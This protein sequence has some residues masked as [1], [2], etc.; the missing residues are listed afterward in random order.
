MALVDYVSLFRSIR[1]HV[2]LQSNLHVS[3]LSDAG[4]RIIQGKDWWLLPD[5]PVRSYAHDPDSTL[6]Q[7]VV[8][9]TCIHNYAGLRL[10]SSESIC[11]DEFLRSSQLPGSILAMGFA[12]FFTSAGE[13]RPCG[14]NGHRC[15]SHLLLLGRCFPPSAG[16]LPSPTNT[17]IHV[18]NRQVTQWFSSHIHVLWFPESDCLMMGTRGWTSNDLKLL[19]GTT[20]SRMPTTGTDSRFNN[21]F[22]FTFCV[23]A[24]TCS[25]SLALFFLLVFP[26]ICLLCTEKR[27]FQIVNI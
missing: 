1:I 9:G 11:P 22:L 27:F 4:R 8:P 16:R 23:I 2:L 14:P 6:C 10:E 20:I 7:P 19:T 3:L 18:S 21:Y 15:R 25:P 13:L 24:I 12:R 5:V 26:R 17:R